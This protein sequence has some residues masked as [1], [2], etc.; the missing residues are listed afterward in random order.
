M[1]GGTE[2]NN[3]TPRSLL[4]ASVFE[5]G[6]FGIQSVIFDSLALEFWFVGLG[7]EL[8]YKHKGMLF[9]SQWP[10]GLR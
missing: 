3:G 1:R 6:A 7:T 8:F 2:K 4:H 10:R 9:R 5:P